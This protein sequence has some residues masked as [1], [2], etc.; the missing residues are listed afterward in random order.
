MAFGSAPALLA[1]L[2]AMAAPVELEVL[3]PDPLILGDVEAVE[4]RLRAPD[5]AEVAGRP[6]RLSVNVGSFGP[7]ERVE[8][9]VY[10][11]RY[12]LP[13]TSFPQVALVAAWRET[14]PDADIRF[15]RI[16]LHGRTEVPI[17]AR[18]G[19][20]VSVRVGEQVFGPVD[21]RR[22]RAR[23]PIVV[24]PGVEQV[25]VTS[26]RGTQRS[27]A[28]V[29]AGVPP[30]NRLTLALTPYKVPSDGESSAV[31]HAYVDRDPPVAPNRVRIAA[32]Q[33]RLERMGSDGPVYRFRFVPDRAEARSDVTIT[34]RVLGDRASRAQVGLQLGLPEPER[35]VVDVD[36][37]R[38]VA[39]GTTPRDVSILVTDRL[40][41]G[42]DGLDLEVKVDTSTVSS[43]LRRGNGRYA[44][45][46][47]PLDAYPPDGSNRIEITL[48]RESGPPLTE[49]VTVPV[50]PPPWPTR[51]ELD[52]TAE[53]VGDDGA[54][55][56]WTAFDAAGDP[57]V[58][59]DVDGGFRLQ[60]DEA[61]AASEDRPD[62]G[63]G[64]EPGAYRAVVPVAPSRRR[65]DVELTHESGRVRLRSRVRVAGHVPRL[66]L[67][68]RAGLVVSDGAFPT[69][70]VDVGYRL[71]VW[72]D[73]VAA[74][75]RASYFQREQ[76]FDVVVFPEGAEQVDA[77]LRLI[78]I[79]LGA[80]VDVVRVDAWSVYAGP[81]GVLAI[82]LEEVDPQFEGGGVER[83]QRVFGGV[84]GVAGVAW[85]G[86]FFELSGAYLPINRADLRAPDYFMTA[87]LGFRGGL[88]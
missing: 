76:S 36:P 53:P 85:R 47:G 25:T 73:R 68:A 17:Q 88:F 82:G 12:T 57:W 41:L 74:R 3:G 18:P 62:V 72:Q 87:A 20:R 2:G 42:V 56:T 66:E 81:F 26:E 6:L 32:P 86:L 16:P 78:P 58:G 23:V 29:A 75:A 33:G 59:D 60:L 43:P 7:V 77:T 44:L 79:S 19:S 35:V 22:G 11:S 28:E 21:A 30:Y 8:P 38:W 1:A 46:L 80:T 4:V 48:P 10:R 55:V 13:T 70:G 39:D 71:P 83:N 45:S 24:P 31:L 64:A 27:Q 52:G 5:T 84:E 14:G 9:G 15:F 34:G 67:G 54:A 37:A 49:A 61:A 63:A 69:G 50:A 65:F 51:V 40:G